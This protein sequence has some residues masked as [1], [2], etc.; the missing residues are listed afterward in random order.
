MEGTLLQHVGACLFFGAPALRFLFQYATLFE[1]QNIDILP[2]FH[3]KFYPAFFNKKFASRLFISNFFHP[4]HKY[5]MLAPLS[6][7]RKYAKLCFFSS[8]TDVRLMKLSNYDDKIIEK[9]FFSS[10]L[11]S[12]MLMFSFVIIFNQQ[13]Q[14][15]L[16]S[17]LL[18]DSR[19]DLTFIDYTRFYTVIYVSHFLHALVFF[20]SKT[21]FLTFFFNLFFQQYFIAFPTI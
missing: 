11:H 14:I 13:N 18:G 15:D 16:Y 4:P 6:N 8:L 5:Q 21:S 19:F 17:H 12:E 2:F 20:L 1:S 7:D 10:E 3:H 9:K